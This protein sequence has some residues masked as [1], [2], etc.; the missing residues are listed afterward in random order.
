MSL[1][2][3]GEVQSRRNSIASGYCGGGAE[4]G[5]KPKK[6][7]LGISLSRIEEAG[8]SAKKSH[9]GQIEIKRAIVDKEDRIDS[10]KLL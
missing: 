3:S 4:E 1:N 9:K 10:S 5:K 7:S 6:Q 2:T 8:M